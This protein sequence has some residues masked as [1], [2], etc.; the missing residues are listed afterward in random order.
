MD[1]EILQPVEKEAET[2]SE[3]KIQEDVKTI[4]KKFMSEDL[5]EIKI[6]IVTKYPRKGSLYVCRS[7]KRQLGN[8]TCIN[9][10]CSDQHF[11]DTVL[12]Q[13]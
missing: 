5:S 7:C 9:G 10:D 11:I 6:S 13:L 8:P 12:E 1:I 3:L 2:T 4:W